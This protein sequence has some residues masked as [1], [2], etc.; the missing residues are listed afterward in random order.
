MTDHPTGQR[1]QRPKKK[2]KISKVD[3]CVSHQPDRRSNLCSTLEK[4]FSTKRTAKET[5]I[6]TLDSP[7]SIH[8]DL[9]AFQVAEVLR[10]SQDRIDP[11]K[12]LCFL[13]I[14]GKMIQVLPKS[15]II[16]LTRLINGGQGYFHKP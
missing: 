13:L 7:R 6:T 14:T 12:A 1:E 15:A 5:R 10:F 2:K 4:P 9:V 8:T 16:K 3:L 11:E